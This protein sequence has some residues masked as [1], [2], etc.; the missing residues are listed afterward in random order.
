MQAV[1]SHQKNYCFESSIRGHRFLMDSSQTSGGANEGPSPKEVLLSSILGC[2]GMDVVAHLQKHK[3]SFDSFKMTA[4]AEPRKEHP[5]VF[6][7]IDIVFELT[8][9]AIELGRVI[10][11]VTL[12][13]TRYCGVSAMVAKV[14][15]IFLTVV[16]NGVVEHRDEARFP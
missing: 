11:A 3:V 2:S 9:K 15:P 10:E 8:G 13:M 6:N 1:V 7:Q 12:S 14:S 16:V 4:N 5:R